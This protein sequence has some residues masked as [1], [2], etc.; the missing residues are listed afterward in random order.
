MGWNWQKNSPPIHIY[1]SNMW[2]D[3][4][5]PCIYDI[6]DLFLGSMYHKIFKVDAPT[7]SERATALITLH[8]DWYVGE[9]FSYFRIWGSKMIHLLP[10]IV[11]DRM[12][13]HEFSFKQSLMAPSQNWP[14]TRGRVGLS[15]RCLWILWS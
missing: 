15:S 7:F 8:G 13:L 9:Y 5:L 6:C 3:N 11:P 2:K 10:I 14:S 4:F 1:C 12:V